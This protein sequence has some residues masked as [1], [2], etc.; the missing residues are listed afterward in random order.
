M[1]PRPPL[2]FPT[3]PN[4]SLTSF[5]FQSSSSFPHRTTLIDADS[6]ETL[7]F[8]QLKTLISKLSYA[9]VHLNVKKGDIVLIL[10]PNSIHFL[11]C[12]FSITALGAIATTCNPAY[13]FFELSNQIRDCNPKIII[14]IPELLEKIEKFNLPHILLQSSSFSDSKL[15]PNSK[16]W[17]YSD[18][19]KISDD[20]VS[21]LPTSNVTQTDQGVS[22][23]HK[24][25]ITT[26]MMVTADQDRYEELNNVFLCFVPMFHIFGLSV[27]TYSQLQRGNSVVS[28]VKFETKKVLMV[29][30]KYRVSHLYV[31]PAVV[32][33]LA[34]LSVSAVKK[35]DL[36][37]LKQ[38]VS[39][40]SPLGKDV[41]ENCS[42]NV[43]HVSINQGYGMTKSCGIIS[44]E[45]LRDG[46]WFSGSTGCLASGIESKIICV[47]TSVPLPPNQLGQICIRGPNMMQAYFKN[48]DAT[49]SSIDGQGWMHTGDLGYF[50]E[51][52]QIF[53]VDRIKELIKCY[54]YQVFL[55]KKKIWYVFVILKNIKFPDEKAGE[56]PIAYVVRSPYSSLSEESVQR[57][58]EKQVAPFQRLRKVIFVSTIPTSASGKIEKVRSKI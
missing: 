54:G 33:A 41:M 9:L 28:M 20:Q 45:N 57:F 6:G 48:P 56:V 46:S 1:F 16:T 32:I 37:F 44:I 10:A 14:T 19:I 13:T 47:E 8:L 35:Y 38:I 4:L 39:G 2:H 42:K 29:I 31:V 43:P 15:A 11:V 5:L 34:K 24:N 18:L 40:A 50:D 52:G 25:F 49:K 26:A 22:L 3:N 51:K 55:P 30:G 7:T 53:V 58:V 36:S 12:F 21:D 27:I 17:Y 23:T